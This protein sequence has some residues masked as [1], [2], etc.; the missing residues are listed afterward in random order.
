MTNNWD[1]KKLYYSEVSNK[2]LII[3][4]NKSY[5]PQ[6]KER[7]NVGDLES[8]GNLLRKE[9]ERIANEFENLLE[10]GR[11]E[12]LG[13]II[14]AL[15]KN[16]IYFKK[17]IKSINSFYLKLQEIII[18]DNNDG[19][20]IKKIKREL[21]NIMNT[22]IDLNETIIDKNGDEEN[23][24][25]SVYISKVNFYNGILLN[26]LSH[27]HDEVEKY[28]KECANVMALLEKIN[29]G[30]SKLKENGYS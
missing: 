24:N 20:K 15:Q 19:I 1:I 23:K 10:L 12:D 7:W 16:K 18:S 17:P 11:V 27:N 26:S 30:L 9:F 28:G 4:Q 8:C 22:K 6:A 13:N 5:I 3:D 2:S 14:N 21:S 25:L 29:K